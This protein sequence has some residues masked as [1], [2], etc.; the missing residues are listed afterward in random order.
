MS[1]RESKMPPLLKGRWYPCKKRTSGFGYKKRLIVSIQEKINDPFHKTEPNE[2][3]K[4]TKI[5]LTPLKQS[6]ISLIQI[7]FL[8]KMDEENSLH[9]EPLDIKDLFI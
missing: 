7:F 3:V 4:R 9:K 8:K 2:L 6:T 5:E 1:E